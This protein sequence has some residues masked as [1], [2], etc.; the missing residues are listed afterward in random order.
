MLGG[1]LSALP[2]VLSY[3]YVAALLVIL[4]ST[5]RP[6]ALLGTAVESIAEFSV[7]NHTDW[8]D[9]RV[10]SDPVLPSTHNLSACVG[11]CRA[12]ADCVAVSW[13]GPGSAPVSLCY[14]Y[15]GGLTDTWYV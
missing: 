4:L 2:M 3:A 1:R 5:P 11:L 12:R 7:L 6:A 9:A 10:S 15:G 8:L 13:S 14:Q